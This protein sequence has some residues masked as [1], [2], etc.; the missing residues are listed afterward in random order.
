[1]NAAKP[2]KVL[3]VEDSRLIHKMYQV[4]LQ[5]MTLVSAYNGQEGLE[6]LDQNPDVDLVILDVNM[7]KMTGL[8]FLTRMRS[9]P[10][11]SRIPVVI[12]STD[13]KDAD[14]ARGLQSGASAYLRKPF[15]R[16]D[17][18]ATISRI[19]PPQTST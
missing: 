6:K 4:M 16:E 13:G 17:L 18:L 14:V 3:I 11:S 9:S 1:V 10:A 19:A 15:H 7:P 2:R 8:E 12:V 5:P